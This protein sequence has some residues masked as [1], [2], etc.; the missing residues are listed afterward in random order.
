MLPKRK[1]HWLLYILAALCLCIWSA[2]LY[3]QDQIRGPAAKAAESQQI[4]ALVSDY[5]NLPLSLDPEQKTSDCH[6]Q[7]A[8]PDHACTPGAVFSEATISQICASGYSKTVRNVSTTLKKHMYAAY[9]ISYP[10]KTGSY[11]VDHLIPL[12]LGGSNDPSNLFPEAAEPTPGFHEKDI[13]EN[14]LHEEVCSGN[15]ELTSAQKQIATDWL[16]VYNSLSSETI[17]ALK[18]E[19]M[20][21]S[22]N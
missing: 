18:Q 20:S 14:Y 6:A 1:E 11:E 8:L 22:S 16:A 4:A 10:Q 19:F 15:L 3:T 12:E 21:W 13:V 9:G 5:N 2:V 7:G 17:A